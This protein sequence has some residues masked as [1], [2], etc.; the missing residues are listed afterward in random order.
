MLF[1]IKQCRPPRD[2]RGTHISLCSPQLGN[3]MARPNRFTPSLP[4]LLLDRH[5]CVKLWLL[6]RAEARSWQPAA[7]RPQFP[8]LQGES[9]RNERMRSP[10]EVPSLPPLQGRERNA[11]PRLTKPLQTRGD[12]TLCLAFNLQTQCRYSK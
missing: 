1:V 5:R 9:P 8:S 12:V 6:M 10:P 11:A 4:R 3:F 7:V 2:A